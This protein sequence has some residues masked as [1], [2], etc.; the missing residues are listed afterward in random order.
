MSQELS[1]RHGAGECH[2]CSA[3][4]EFNPR[5]DAAAHASGVRTSKEWS[6]DFKLSSIRGTRWT[7]KEGGVGC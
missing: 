2:D 5:H 7:E 1:V 3:G 4:S 6:R